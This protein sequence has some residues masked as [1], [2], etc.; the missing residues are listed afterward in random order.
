VSKLINWEIGEIMEIYSFAIDK[1]GD[2]G[3]M[4]TNTEIIIINKKYV[5]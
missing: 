1:F 5:F 2:I 3:I 4:M